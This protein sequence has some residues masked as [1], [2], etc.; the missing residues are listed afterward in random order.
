MSTEPPRRGRHQVLI[1]KAQI[2][3]R[4]LAYRLLKGELQ[5]E[6]FSIHPEGGEGGEGFGNAPGKTKHEIG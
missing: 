6:S 1:Y 3:A 5:A 2:R 4:G